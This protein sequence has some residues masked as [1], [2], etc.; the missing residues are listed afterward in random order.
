MKKLILPITAFIILF[1]FF[2]N[3]CRLDQVDPL[4]LPDFGVGFTIES[5]S[6]NGYAPATVIFNYTTTQTGLTYLWDFGDGETSTMNKPTHVYNEP[7]MYQVELTVTHAESQES[8]IFTQEVEIKKIITFNKII[9]NSSRRQPIQI[10]QNTDGTYLILTVNFDNR[11]IELFF[12]N[13]EGE[14]LKTIHINPTTTGLI[15]Y[16]WLGANEIIKT[17]SGYAIVG[18]CL[19]PMSQDVFLILTD[20]QGNLLNNTPKIYKQLV[21]PYGNSIIRTDDGYA[22]LGTELKEGGAPFGLYLIL[23]HENGDEKNGSPKTY[24]EEN[25]NLRGNIITHTTDN[26]FLMIGTHLNNEYERDIYFVLT[27]KDG[28]QNANSPQH[29]GTPENT[30]FP[31]GVVSTDSGF[32]L[33]YK[34]NDKM[35]LV[36]IDKYGTAI[37]TPHEY[38]GLG[39]ERH[40]IS[41]TSDNGFALIGDYEQA[42]SDYDICL[43]LTDAQGNQ[44]TDSP[45]FYGSTDKERGYSVIQTQDGGLALLGLRGNLQPTGGSTNLIFIK[46]DHKGTVE[47]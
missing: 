41:K 44:T 31:L 14:T 12:L 47:Q 6:N 25:G 30:E 11:G 22:L 33:Y 17:D 24:S 18:S 3:S 15:G 32:A 43:V 37:T 39:N 2:M 7:G 21:N 28:I 1:F 19:N 5:I 34:S 35:S 45:L 42:G 40:S 20:K 4:V 23:T 29:L 10:L 16:D 9:P 27:D 38:D 36:F 13:E 8:K 46:T 26:D